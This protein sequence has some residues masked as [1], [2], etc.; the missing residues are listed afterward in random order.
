MLDK[1]AI[2]GGVPVR[3]DLLA[4]G[5]PLI[6]QDE[7]DEV[8]DTLRSGWLSTGPK[9]AIFEERFKEYIGVRHAIALNSCTAGLH[10]ALEVCGIKPGDEVITTPFTFCA[11]ANVITHLGAK[12]VFSDIDKDTLCI[13]PNEIERNITSRTKAIIPVH[14]AGQVCRMDE[15]YDIAK[16]YNLRVIQDA[17]HAIEATYKGK[18]VGSFPDLT[19]YS[20]Y[21]TKN[22]TTGEGG[23]V[24]TDNDSFAEKIRVLRLHGLTQDAWRRYEE[25]RHYDVTIAGYKYNMMDIQAALGIRQLEKLERYLQ[26]RER[27]FKMYDE[28]FSRIQGIILPKSIPGIRHARHLYVIML[29]LEQIT[30]GRDEFLEALKAE[31]IGTGIHFI[32]LHLHSFYRKAGY[33]KGDFPQSEWAG[34]RI[35][36]LPMSAGLTTKD[37]EDVISAVKKIISYY[38][39]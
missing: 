38:R 30:I 31:N 16:R 26:I 4:F 5:K 39:K 29:D 20:F 1:P 17:A 27:Y 10:L 12:V 19:S 3:E 33:K 24:V 22:L 13:D 28:A 8:V 37:I 21:A 34:E 32:P 23:A 11:T 15:I 25:V 2:L 7:I 36:S 35:L 9:V 18:K 14:F 6:S